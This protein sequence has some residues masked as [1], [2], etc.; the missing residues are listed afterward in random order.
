MYKSFLLAAKWFLLMWE[1]NI[2]KYQNWWPPSSS[3]VVIS[4]LS[5]CKDIPVIPPTVNKIIKKKKKHKKPFSME[6]TSWWKR[7][8]VSKVRPDA[9]D[10]QNSESLC[11]VSC[12]QLRSPQTKLFVYKFNCFLVLFFSFL[13]KLCYKKFGKIFC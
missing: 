1:P 7:S 10:Y 3:D 2:G 4:E 9:F 13:N 12:H 5:K 6:E 11:P 8:P